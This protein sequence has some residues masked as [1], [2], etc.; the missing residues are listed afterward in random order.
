[1]L[2][3]LPCLMCPFPITKVEREPVSNQLDPGPWRDE[4]RSLRRWLLALS[5]DSAIRLVINRC[6]VEVVDQV[7]WRGGCRL[8]KARTIA[9]KG[10]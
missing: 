1:M 5:A 4:E 10:S 7:T 3:L 6:G 2:L 9:V 8:H